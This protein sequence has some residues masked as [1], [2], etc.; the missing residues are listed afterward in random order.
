MLLYTVRLYL[1][2]EANVFAPDKKFVDALKYLKSLITLHCGGSGPRSEL[3][4]SSRY[5]RV[6]F[7]A[8]QL[9][10]RVPA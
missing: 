10:G 1:W 7:I 9:A 8:A 3:F 2:L 5:F 6:L 4:P